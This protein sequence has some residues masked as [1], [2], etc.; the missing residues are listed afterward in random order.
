MDERNTSNDKEEFFHVV[1]DQFAKVGLSEPAFQDH[2]DNYFKSLIELK[3]DCMFEMYTD[4][5]LT[6]YLDQ[7]SLAEEPLKF[8]ALPFF[9]P[10][11]LLSLK[12]GSSST[13]GIS[14]SQRPIPFS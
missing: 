2:V 7:E 12:T 3:K 1:K 9:M 11:L 13:D 10:A 4:T 6:P 8:L 5:W 14:L